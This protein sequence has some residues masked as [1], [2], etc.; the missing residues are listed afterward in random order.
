[1]SSGNSTG[2]HHQAWGKPYII[3]KP[4]S[5][6][7]PTRGGRWGWEGEPQQDVSQYPV[8]PQHKLSTFL[9]GFSVSHTDDSVAT[10]PEPHLQEWPDEAIKGGVT[11]TQTNTTPHPS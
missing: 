10:R 7:R 2:G 9:C 11:H 1:M 6:G 5:P 3:L 4:I 8:F